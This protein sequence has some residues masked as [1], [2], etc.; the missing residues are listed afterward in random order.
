MID[1]ISSKSRQILSKSGRVIYTRNKSLRGAIVAVPFVL[2]AVVSFIY[3]RWNLPPWWFSEIVVFSP[4]FFVVIIYHCRS[5]IYRF[6]AGAPLLALSLGGALLFP[7][8]VCI[9]IPEYNVIDNGV[10]A[11]IMLIAW[12]TSTYCLWLLFQ[13]RRESFWNR[14]LE[15]FQKDPRRWAIIV[16]YPMVWAAYGFGVFQLID[17]RFDVSKSQVIQLP[18]VRKTE[19]SRIGSGPQ[20]YVR[21]SPWAWDYNRSPRDDGP[22]VPEAVFDR[23]SV[24]K[25]AC[26]SL[27]HGL[28]G[29]PW[30]R[31]DACER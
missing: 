7:M 4:L 12:G 14:V 27:H 18:V 3:G 29:A 30:Y 2:A 19:H 5:W 6:P 1:A 11:G 31:V 26:V 22:Q 10:G 8:D 17:T 25:A 24:G 15:R 23:L 28:L 20:F 21:L 9:H 16:V 13:P